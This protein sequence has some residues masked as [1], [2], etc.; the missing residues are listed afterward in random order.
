MSISRRCQDDL[1]RLARRLDADAHRIR[2]R[3]FAAIVVPFWMAFGLFWAAVGGDWAASS[4]VLGW[5]LLAVADYEFVGLTPVLVGDEPHGWV[6]IGMRPTGLVALGLQPTG[7]IAVGL[8]PIGAVSVGVVALGLLPLG[9]VAAGLVSIGTVSAAWLS[10]GSRL[11]LGWFALGDGPRKG[12]SIGAYA[13]GNRAHG[14]L[15]EKRRLREALDARPA[16]E[17]AQSIV[18]RG[19]QGDLRRLA[20][21]LDGTDAHRLRRCAFWTG[22]VACTMAIA[23]SPFALWDS[24]ASTEVLGRPLVA[25]G[26]YEFVGGRAVFVGDEPRGWAWVSIGLRPT[27]FVAIGVAPAGVIALGLVPQGVVSVGMVAIDLLPFG[28]AVFGLVSYGM[29]SFGWISFG[30][31][32]VG[33]YAL[34]DGAMGAYAWGNQVACGFLF[35]RR[36]SWKTL[37]NGSANEGNNGREQHGQ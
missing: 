19:R 30:R 37:G 16:N 23:V 29:V 27:G 2:Q 15:F 18:P 26:N 5:P 36:R 11:S 17:G 33:W 13:W 28:C 10:F 24:L 9:C 3:V 32:C 34:G 4:E 14:L 6:S 7:V 1:P 31:A 12:T 25:V 20:R 35:A 8:L 21:R 22:V